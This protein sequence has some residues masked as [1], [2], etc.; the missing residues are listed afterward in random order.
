L[1]LVGA[2]LLALVMALVPHPPE[3]P[4]SDKTQHMLAFAVMAGLALPALP[5]VHPLAIAVWLAGFG[6]LIEILQ[7]IPALHRDSSFADWIADMI[8]VTI[9]LILGAPLRRR[10]RGG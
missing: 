5:R 9:V 8:A 10:L 3:L 4:M 6:A 2:S 7:E 1:L